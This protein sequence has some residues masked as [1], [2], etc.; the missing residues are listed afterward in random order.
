[1]LV[2]PAAAA[3][4]TTLSV[5][6]VPPVAKL[7]KSITASLPVTTALL[8]SVYVN[9]TFLLASGVYVPGVMCNSVSFN[10]LTLTASVSSVPGATL[11]ILL[12]PKS[13]LPPVILMELPPIVIVGPPVV[14]AIDVIPF[15]SP[16]TFTLYGS[17]V[18]PVPVTVVFVPSVTFVKF[19]LTV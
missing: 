3:F 5:E 17:A 19:A 9:L 15:K 7:D 14:L 13:K 16:D 18:V 11:V 1:M 4:L 8:P 2:S 12:L 10:C 6:A